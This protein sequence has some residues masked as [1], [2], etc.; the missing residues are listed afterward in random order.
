MNIPNLKQYNNQGENIL[1]HFVGIINQNTTLKINLVTPIS[2]SIAK[3]FQE[4]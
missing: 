1:I 4:S 2:L 3:H